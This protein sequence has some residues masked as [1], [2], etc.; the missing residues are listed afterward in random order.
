MNRSTVQLAWLTVAL[1]SI[2]LVGCGDSDKGPSTPIPSGEGSIAAPVDLGDPA[3]TTPHTAPMPAFGRNFYQFTTTV[4]TVHIIDIA[5]ISKFS[6]ILYSTPDFQTT[7]S[8]FCPIMFNPQC[9][10]GS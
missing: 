8:V 7:V 2:L 6:W 3:L 10:T 9:S 5:S 4:G 1:A